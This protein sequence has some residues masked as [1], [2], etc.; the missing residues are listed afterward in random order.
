MNG[1]TMDYPL[2]LSTIF[3]RAESLSQ[4]A[5]IIAHANSLHITASKFGSARRGEAR[6][7]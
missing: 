3:R 6:K 7:A 2:T 1:L 5:G 4:A